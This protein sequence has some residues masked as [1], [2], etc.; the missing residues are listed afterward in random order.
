[1]MDQG[2]MAIG[3]LFIDKNLLGEHLDFRA[4]VDDI[5]TRDDLTKHST[6]HS[7]GSDSTITL[8]RPLWSLASEWAAGA[9]FT[10]R[11]AIDRQF[12]GTQLRTYPYTDPETMQVT[13]FDRAYEMR[14]WG[15]NAFVTRQ[16]GDELKQQL[17]LGHGF[18]SQ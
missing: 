10:H 4:R 3:P 16:W 14:R 2:A 13:A 1:T 9:S 15:T 17:S 11:F 8:S 5:L 18:N 12:L 6:L 7:E